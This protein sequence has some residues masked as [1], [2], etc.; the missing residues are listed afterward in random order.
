MVHSVA[1]AYAWPV[2][3]PQ[4]RA[5]ITLSAMA[6]RDVAGKYSATISNKHV[7]ID[8]TMAP[9]NGR[10]A[11]F[12]GMSFDNY[13]AQLYFA[14]LYPEAPLRFFT[15]EGASLLFKTNGAGRIASVQFGGST[16]ARL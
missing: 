13:P 3:Q 10:Q 1:K 5:A 14:Q 15:L 9:A 16:F 11:L 6:L 8:V 7:S 2:L 12:V 4:P